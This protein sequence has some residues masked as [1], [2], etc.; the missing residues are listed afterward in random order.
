MILRKRAWDIVKEMRSVVAEERLIEVMKKLDE[1][2]LEAPEAHTLLVTDKEGLLLGTVSVWDIL[3]FA[4]DTLM[5]YGIEKDADGVDIDQ[6]VMVTCRKFADMPISSIMSTSV[7]RVNPSDPLVFIL[8]KFLRGGRSTA[9][10]EEGGR[11]IGGINIV[12]V[13]REICRGLV[14]RE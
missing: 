3:S 8:D 11:V 7:Q 2:L 6:A 12:D 5:E 13:Y 9:V 1:T 14:G 4:S 10:V